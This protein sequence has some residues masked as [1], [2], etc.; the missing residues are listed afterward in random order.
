MKVFFITAVSYLPW[1]NIMFADRDEVCTSQ[2][3][4]VCDRLLLPARLYMDL[5]LNLP[6]ITLALSLIPGISGGI[7][8]TTEVLPF[9]IF[10]YFVMCAAPFVV[11]VLSLWPMLSLVVHAMDS[12]F[13]MVGVLFYV[14][15]AL[16]LSVGALKG[17]FA[18]SAFEELGKEMYKRNL[19]NAMDEGNG[20]GKPVLLNMEAE[21]HQSSGAEKK[22]GVVRNTCKSEEEVGAGEAA[23]H[24]LLE[25]GAEPSEVFLDPEEVSAS[26]NEKL[27]S[28]YLPH[29]NPPVFLDGSHRAEDNDNMGS[30]QMLTSSQQTHQLPT[31][32]HV[33]LEQPIASANLGQ[34]EITSDA[35]VA[36]SNNEVAATKQP[37]F[38]EQ[39][40]KKLSFFS[41]IMEEKLKTRNGGQGSDSLGRQPKKYNYLVGSTFLS[42]TKKANSRGKTSGGKSVDKAASDE[43]P[44]D[45]EYAFVQATL[46]R[47]LCVKVKKN[48][49]NVMRTSL[50]MQIIAYSMICLAI[51]QEGREFVDLTVSSDIV[52]TVMLLF[53][54]AFVNKCMMD[55]ITIDFTFDALVKMRLYNGYMADDPDLSNLAV[56]FK[57]S[58]KLNAFFC[59]GVA[60]AQTKQHELELKKAGTGGFLGK[61][62]AN[63][64]EKFGVAAGGKQA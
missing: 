8:S 17:M 64:Q 63:V 60:Q 49:M 46:I 37:S 5:I 4:E 28:G 61:M 33:D 54:D 11:V 38:K 3:E 45:T 57:F 19:Q 40:G 13:L 39:V 51:V 23:E 62:K 55:M 34:T 47:H 42:P 26:G 25:N 15:Y 21:N 27:A 52:A 24:S 20:G 48:M 9:T 14:L 36:S 56:L 41:H 22:N 31:T 35:E 16:V 1:F 12:P 53:T 29:S 18:M 6:V 50:F 58:D 30:S 7:M 44:S 32:V 2:S 59:K 43:I 10:P